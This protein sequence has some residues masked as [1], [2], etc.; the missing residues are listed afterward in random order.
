MTDKITRPQAVLVAVVR[1]AAK[2]GSCKQT[3][4]DAGLSLQAMAD[5]C[6]GVTATT[7]F[8]WERGSVPKAAAALRWAAVLA[9]LERVMRP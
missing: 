8:N 3:R 5:A 9:G 4:L 6:G 1:R 2:N 7:V